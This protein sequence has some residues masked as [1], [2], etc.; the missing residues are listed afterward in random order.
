MNETY[1]QNYIIYKSKIKKGL[2]LESLQ[3]QKRYEWN[4]SKCY[5]DKNFLKNCNL[6]KVNK[7]Y[8]QTQF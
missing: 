6:K 2:Q 8:K 3:K 1:K 4:I 7:T 5:V